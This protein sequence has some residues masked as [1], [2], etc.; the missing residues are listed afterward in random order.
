MTRRTYSLQADA[1]IDRRESAP[2]SVWIDWRSSPE[3]RP[4]EERTE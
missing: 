3:A 1:L 4:W 2:N